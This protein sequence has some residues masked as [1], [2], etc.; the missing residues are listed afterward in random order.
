MHV[1]LSG[2]GAHLLGADHPFYEG[3]VITVILGFAVAV[4]YYAYGR[5]VARA[6]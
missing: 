2:Q 4:M 1:A 6:M 3:M 5:Y